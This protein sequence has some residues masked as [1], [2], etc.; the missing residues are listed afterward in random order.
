MKKLAFICLL[1]SL[2]YWVYGQKE[3]RSI[4]PWKG[5]NGFQ[6]ATS[7]GERYYEAEASYL[8][9]SSQPYRG[10]EDWD[11]LFGFQSISLGLD[12]VNTKERSFIGPKAYYQMTFVILAGQ[13]GFDYL[14]D[15]KGNS[16]A[17]VTPKIGLSFFGFASVMYGR[18]YLL[19]ANKDNG[20]AN[21]G[22]LNL[23]V[24]IPVGKNFF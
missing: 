5:L 11:A 15:F 7:I 13:V 6:V 4:N 3:R 20:F 22:T 24:Q 2:S 17:R 23:Q 8:L 18:N 14:S 19:G 9:T 1:T 21:Q 10:G 16:Q 12:Y